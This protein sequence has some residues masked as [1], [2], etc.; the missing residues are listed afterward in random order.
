[1]DQNDRE[2]ILLLQANAREP[3]ASLA[4]KLH[5]SRTTVQERMN[6]LERNGTIVN[7]TVK[8]DANFRHDRLFAVVRLT[9]SPKQSKGIVAY[10]KKMPEVETC[11]AVSGAYD[12]IVT[13]SAET[14]SH[15]H[16]LLEELGTMP[17]LE[18]TTSSIV[19]ATE[20]DRRL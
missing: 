7:Y 6:R 10:L 16:Q 19:L 5:L 17:G 15:L 11:Y 2:L 9:T 13:L 14:P 20:I 3:I 18:R 1:M 4:R 12:L 8:L